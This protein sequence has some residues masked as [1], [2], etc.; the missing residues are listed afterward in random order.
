MQFLDG[1]ECIKKKLCGY[2]NMAVCGTQRVLTRHGPMAV[3]QLPRGEP[4]ELWD[5]ESFQRTSATPTGRVEML[6]IALTDGSVV[7][8]AR[9]RA[10]HVPTLSRG[11]YRKPVAASQLRRGVRLARERA[12]PLD[13]AAPAAALPRAYEQ[14]AY[15]VA[16][17][18]GDGFK[19][20][21]CRNGVV[22]ARFDAEVGEEVDVTGLVRFPKSH[23][24]A[25]SNLDSKRQWL[26]GFFDAM[27]VRIVP[28]FP[29]TFSFRDQEFM[30]EVRIL[31]LTCGVRCSLRFRPGDV[32]AATLSAS[33]AEGLSRFLEGREAADPDDNGRAAGGGRSRFR[34]LSLSAPILERAEKAPDPVYVK[35]VK[36]LARPRE[37]F[38][39]PG[40]AVV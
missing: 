22:A 7:R 23:V 33:A 10:F 15:S 21:A 18:E 38:V 14:G 39:V 3:K 4:L 11:A 16:G 36:H 26:S 6:E 31:L 5:G 27:N 24:P 2:V 20:V 13:P 35:S 30:K 28:G 1:K 37:G 29:K 40:A 17:R 12:P 9:D 19:T 34:L 8:C 25:R 32:A